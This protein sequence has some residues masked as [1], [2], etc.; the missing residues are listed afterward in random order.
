MHHTFCTFLFSLRD[1]NVWS[2]SFQVLWR[3]WTQHNNFE[4]P[5]IHFLRDVF[6]AVRS[7]LLLKL[8]NSSSIGYGLFLNWAF[9]CLHVPVK[10]FF[11]FHFLGSFEVILTFLFSFFHVIDV[12]RGRLAM[13]FRRYSQYEKGCRK[14]CTR[15]S[16]KVLWVVFS[17]MFFKEVSKNGKRGH[18]RISVCEC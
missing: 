18:G 13:E 8:P 10:V 4:A 7:S 2:A 15:Q 16:G 12:I 9:R 3:T 17:S 1:Y 11:V 5:R 6:V 14:K